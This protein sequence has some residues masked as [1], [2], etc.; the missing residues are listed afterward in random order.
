M[1]RT[2]RRKSETGIYHVML[3]GI[4]KRDLFLDEED[5]QKFLDYIVKAKKKVEFAV[6]GYC[7]Q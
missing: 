1:V 5:Y 3:R 4:D 7:L 6:Y 2:V